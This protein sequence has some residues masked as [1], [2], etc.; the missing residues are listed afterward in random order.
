M[1]E[2]FSR[3]SFDATL[4]ECVEVTIRGAGRS[5]AIQ[6]ARRNTM[7]A[8]GATV[9]ILLLAAARELW[10]TSDAIPVM[11]VVAPLVGWLIAYLR[12]LAFDRS[13]AKRIRAHLV[14]KLHG[15]TLRCEVELRSS[16]LW[17]R[18]DNVEHLHRWLDVTAVEDTAISVDIFA[19]NFLLVVRNRAFFSPAERQDFLGHARRLA[20]VATP[21]TAS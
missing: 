13:A 20:S 5:T 7:L 14:E 15:S 8:S 21:E 4:D 1:D 19:K 9:T 11:G 17:Y 12:G 2:I 10:R 18:W 3:A 6:R 16:G